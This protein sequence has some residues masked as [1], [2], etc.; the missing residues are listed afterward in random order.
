MLGRDP[1]SEMYRVAI[2]VD[3]RRVVGLVP[4]R[5]MSTGLP[6][7]GGRGH[8]IAYEWLSRHG[9][10]IEDTLKTLATGDGRVKAPFDTVVLAEEN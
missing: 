1:A 6:L 9:K 7:T 8:G 10:Q 3:G 4:E 2:K 5:L